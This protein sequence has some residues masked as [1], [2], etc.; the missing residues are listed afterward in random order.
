VRIIRLICSGL[1][2]LAMTALIVFVL[3]ATVLLVCL[4]LDKLL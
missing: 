2:E 4:A 3:G 1:Y